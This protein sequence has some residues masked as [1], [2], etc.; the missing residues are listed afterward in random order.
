MACFFL[1]KAKYPPTAL[2]SIPPLRG[3][4]CTLY[5]WHHVSYFCE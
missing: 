5:F 1:Y 4:H 2:Q 3:W